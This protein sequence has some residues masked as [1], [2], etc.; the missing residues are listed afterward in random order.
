MLGVEEWLLTTRGRVLSALSALLFLAL[1]VGLS[2]AGV[3]F[4][5]RLV[6]TFAGLAA[7]PAAAYLASLALGRRDVR[8]GRGLLVVW[9]TYTAAA[10]LVINGPL[11]YVLANPRADLSGP[12]T[13]GF[14]QGFGPSF[15]LLLMYRLRRAP[16]TKDVYRRW[17]LAALGLYA[18]GTALAVVIG[19]AVFVYAFGP[20]TR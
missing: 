14:F 6:F 8:R 17:V 9:I 16:R 13:P 3:G 11:V 18:S 10:V 4:A 19:I 7:G 15:W 2:L 5:T 20:P 1:L 12:A